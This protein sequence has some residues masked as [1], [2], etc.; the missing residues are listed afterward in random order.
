MAVGYRAPQQSTTVANAAS[1]TTTTQSQ[2]TS[3]DNVVAT[4]LAANLA[5]TTNLSVAPNVASLAVSAK[6]SSE[7]AQ[8]SDTSLSK[9]QI[10]QPTADSRAIKSYTAQ[11]GDTTDSLAAK[12]GVSNDTIKWANGLI[13]DTLTVGKVLQ[14]LPTDGV[15]YTVKAGDTAQSIGDKYKV[16]P[17]RIILY[18]DLEEGGLKAGIKIILPGAILPNNE[19]PGY[20]APVVN[21]YSYSSGS[22]FASGSV[23][24][25]YAFG[26]CTWYAYE[27]RAQM[28]HPVGSFWGN[29]STWAIAARANGYLV[30]KHP[31]AGAVLQI[32][33]FGDRWTGYA[34][35]VAIVER[36]DPNGDVFVSE[37][38]YGGNFNRVTYRTIS[39]GQ[40]ALY[41][42]IH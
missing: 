29:A 28:G 4:N 21:S 32:D 11:V 15:L 3:V 13:G 10:I 30:D 41:N 14:I 37:M 6:I 24:N 38:N 26:N 39:A 22:Y 7:L 12:F 17:T 19:R 31:S 1:L 36:V 33:G 42:Y 20:V 5:E 25:R 40:A 34:G 2:Q 16:D 18:N 23:G 35:H 8:T 27:R 9:P